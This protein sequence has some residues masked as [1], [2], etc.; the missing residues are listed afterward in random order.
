MPRH[1]DRRQGNI[2]PNNASHR[3]VNPD[4]LPNG[5][6][7]HGNVTIYFARK[8]ELDKRLLADL[9][10]ELRKWSEG[11]ENSVARHVLPWCFRQIISC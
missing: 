4:G 11:V 10:D 7:G 8:A 6:D 3:I 9:G 5:E 2:Q 1:V